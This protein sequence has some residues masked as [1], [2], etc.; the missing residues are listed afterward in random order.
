MLVHD[1]DI[2]ISNATTGQILRQLTLD[3]THR[4]QPQNGGLPET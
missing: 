2:T 1:L 3:P 4:Y